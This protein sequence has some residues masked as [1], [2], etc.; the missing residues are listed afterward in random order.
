ML[1]FSIC[2]FPFQDTIFLLL[3]ALKKDLQKTDRNSEKVKEKVSQ[4]FE[5]MAH[6]FDC[7]QE[8]A[9]DT[10]KNEED[11]EWLKRVRANLPASFGSC[12]RGFEI[13]AEK[14]LKRKALEEERAERQ[15]KKCEEEKAVSEINRQKKIH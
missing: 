3:R 13:A 1:S 8:N 12:D 2:Q 10:C 6:R 4:W 11:R 14:H 7:S 9:L 5:K 15:K